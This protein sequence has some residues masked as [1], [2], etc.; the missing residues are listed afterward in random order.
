MFRNYTNLI[1]FFNKNKIFFINFT[2]YDN[3]EF[4]ISMQLLFISKLLFKG[5]VGISKLLL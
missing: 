2:I 3:L 5:C 4:M 1:V